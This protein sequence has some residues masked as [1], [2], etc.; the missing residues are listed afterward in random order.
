MTLGYHAIA[1]KES[2]YVPTGNS[3]CLRA[4]VCLEIFRKITYDPGFISTATQV[5]CAR[6][7][8]SKSTEVELSSFDHQTRFYS[9]Y[10]FC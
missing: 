10:N 5:P 3:G 4:F 2:G 9:Y 6:V 7:R 1:L 8:L